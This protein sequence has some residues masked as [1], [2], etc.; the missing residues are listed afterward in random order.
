MSA[1][2]ARR[3]LATAL[4][5][6]G[7]SVLVFGMVRLV[8][9]TIVEQLLGQAAMGSPEVLASFRRF[10]GLDRPAHLQYLDWLGSALRGD[11][12][13]SWLSGKPVL[14]LFLERLPVSAELALLA[15]GWSLLLGV[16]LGTASAMWRGGARD[17]AIRVGATLGLSLP[18]FW[19]GTV[20]ILLFSVYLGWMPSLQWVSLARNPAANLA[21]M[22]LPALTLGT[23][24]A[25]MI[26]RM[27]RSS[28]LDVLGREYI[29]TARAKGV[30]ER[31][32]T[33]HHALRNALIPVVTVAGVQLGYIVGGIVVVEDVFTLPGVGRLLLDAIFQRDYPV[34][35]GVILLLG[36]IF[37]TLNLCVDLLYAALDPRLRRE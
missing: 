36:A 25:A 26:T 33:F 12:G 3:L 19:Q 2:V 15:V 27:S 32:V 14:A 34:V 20:L 29:R 1:Y 10:F 9:G 22:A 17:G 5:L 37:M 21:T 18:A 4:T 8:P 35:Q 6:L 7:V 23:A 24:T 31:R 28:M 30:S 16:P 13:V 11:L